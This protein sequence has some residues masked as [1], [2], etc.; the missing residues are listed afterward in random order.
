MID[1]SGQ[2][3]VPSNASTPNTQVLQANMTMGSYGTSQTTPTA[4]IS[5]QQCL[6]VFFC[7]P[8]ATVA[9]PS[10]NSSRLPAGVVTT[11]QAAGSEFLIDCTGFSSDIISA[12]AGIITPSRGNQTLDCVVSAVDNV[13]KLVYVQVV[14]FATG[15]A[16]AATIG[17]AITFQIVMKDSAGT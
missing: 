4:Q 16:T 9:Q 13:N 5:P 14:S 11:A 8:N 1:C 2:F 12:Q 7:T 6:F 15:A 17:S 3:I 10:T